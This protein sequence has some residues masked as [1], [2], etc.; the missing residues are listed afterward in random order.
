MMG[1]GLTAEALENVHLAHSPR[2]YHP[3]RKALNLQRF[4]WRFDNQALRV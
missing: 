4:L 1:Q 3:V 2:A